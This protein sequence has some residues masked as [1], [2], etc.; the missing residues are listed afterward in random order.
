MAGHASDRTPLGLWLGSQWLSGPTGPRGGPPLFND[1]FLTIL[2]WQR[3]A[4]SMRL[5]VEVSALGCDWCFGFGGLLKPLAQHY[6]HAPWWVPESSM[7]MDDHAWSFEAGHRPCVGISHFCGI[8]FLRLA[9]RNV[10][11][12]CVDAAGHAEVLLW[13]HFEREIARGAR[14]SLPWQTPLAKLSFHWRVIK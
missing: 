5:V 7:P 12:K 4:R 6:D 14:G 1:R 2:W 11:D 10:P 13:Q 9:P 3:T 8:D